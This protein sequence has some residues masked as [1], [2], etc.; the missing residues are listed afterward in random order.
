MKRRL[1]AL[2][3]VIALLIAACGGDE[4]TEDTTGTTAGGATT[5]AAAEEPTTT[6]A[7]GGATTTAAAGGDGDCLVGMS[8]NNYNEERWAKHDEPAI[9]AALEAGGCAY[10]STDA[11]SSEEQQIAD[12]ENLINQGADVIVILAQNT[13]AILP[14]V[15]AATDQG[16]PVIAYDRLIED[17][18]TF[19][20]SFDNVLVGQLMAEVVFDLVP[21]GNYFIIKGNGAD[22]NSDFL[23]E[24]IGS[25]IDAAA[26]AGDI[27]ILEEDYTDNWDPSLAQTTTE[28]WLSAHDNDVQA[29]VSE[30]DG[31]ATGAAAALDA[32]GLLGTVVLSGQDADVAALQ[33][34][35]AG[36][37]AVSVWKDARALGTAAGEAAVQLA[38]GASLADVEGTSEFTYTNKET[39]A[40]TVLTSI[41]LT[42]IPITQDNLQEVVDA[43]WISADELCSTGGTVG[44]CA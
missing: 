44:P 15:Q 41:L 6:A 37:Q 9:Q 2:V 11:G 34:V 38:G 1:W 12:V 30:N 19:Y 36:T 7:D 22:A 24:G 39:Q 13:L 43:E 5:T 10:T 29:I 40:E 20:V 16:I 23:R 32:Q 31:M 18:N 17:A 21:T 3:A 26:E 33:R 25:V 14:A 35:A 28:Q 4:G 8:W 27:V 42:P